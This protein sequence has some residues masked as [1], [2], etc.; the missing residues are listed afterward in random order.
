MAME[1]SVSNDF[2]P[3]FFDNSNLF[4]CPLPCVFL[5]FNYFTHSDLREFLITSCP[6]LTSTFSSSK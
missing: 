5:D 1:N 2:L 3:T 6:K 4:D